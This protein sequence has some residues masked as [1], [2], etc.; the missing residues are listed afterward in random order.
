MRIIAK[1]TLREFWKRHPD[2]E[3]PL[4]AWYRE[5]K[6]ENWETPASIKEKYRNASILGGSRAVFD[7][8]GNNYRLVT[9]VDYAHRLVRIRF[10]GTHD[11]YAGIDAKRI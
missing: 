3:R 11:Q 8:K 2:A 10:I 5:V 7:I 9:E 6:K 4:L 1:K